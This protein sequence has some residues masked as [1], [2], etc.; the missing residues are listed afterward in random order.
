M[1]KIQTGLTRLHHCWF[2]S[3][4][5][6]LSIT[7]RLPLYISIPLYLNTSIYPIPQCILS[8]SV[9]YGKRKFYS[10]VTDTAATTYSPRRVIGE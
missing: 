3:L 10:R 1:K 4:S 6:S 2:L 8:V 7:I 5:I 9:Y